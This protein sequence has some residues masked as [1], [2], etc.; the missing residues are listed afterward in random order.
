MRDFLKLRQ[1][2]DRWLRE[3][4]LRRATRTLASLNTAK[5]PDAQRL[6]IAKLARRAN[7]IS[8]GLRILSPLIL[9]ADGERRH[10]A[11]D[12]ATAEYG[13][14]LHN[15]GSTH[16]GLRIL[17]EV[18]ASRFPE[19]LLN[20]A[21]CHFSR[22]E[23][24]EAR[25]PLIQYVDSPGLDEYSRAV[26][27]INLIAIHVFFDEDALAR[28][29]LAA[30]MEA[31]QRSGYKRLLANAKELAAQVEIRAQN[32][33][34]ADRWLN[35][36]AQILSG[37]KTA[38][39]FYIQKWKNVCDAFRTGQT[40]GLL[41]FKKTAIRH[42]E[43]ESVRSCDLQLVKINSD[44]DLFRHLYAGTPYPAYRARLATREGLEFAPPHEFTLGRGRA[45]LDL[46]S[47]E[48]NGKPLLKAGTK[49]HQFLKVVLSDFYRPVRIGDLF[50]S[51]FPDENFNIFSSPLRIHQFA[52]RIRQ[53][54]R[55]HE[56]G[57]ELTEQLGS[58]HYKMAAGLRIRV[59]VETQLRDRR[60]LL[61]QDLRARFGERAF[62]AKEAAAALDL[63]LSS[64]TRLLRQG[65]NAGNFRRTGAG[66][67]TRYIVSI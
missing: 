32:F 5:I 26:G 23:Y 14:L 20:K 28:A 41:D 9:N 10:D 49:V 59:E 51:L 36:A 6:P 18:D 38:D 64:V 57:L 47:G 46:E 33:K 13:I 34:V 48:L 31:A 53:L 16:E 17:Q 2:C 21:F 7:L 29:E 24:E 19:V 67:L 66:P 37:G 54:F 58:Y 60:D 43:W 12:A 65:L 35:E 61:A 25:H 55:E 56:L 4:E 44:E 63:S 42:R 50:T 8:T 27:R 11:G 22:W 40:R 3:G 39:L 62:S 45:L 52:A 1:E 15:M 30:F